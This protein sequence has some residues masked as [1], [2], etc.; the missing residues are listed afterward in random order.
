LPEAKANE[1]PTSTHMI[2]MTAMAIM[3]WVI[4]AVM[5]CFLSIPP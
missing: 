3:V 5:L 1:K 4:V 2:P